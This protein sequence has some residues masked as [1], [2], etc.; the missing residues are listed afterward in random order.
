MQSSAAILYFIFLVSDQVSFVG[1]YTCN[2]ITDSRGGWSVRNVNWVDSIWFILETLLEAKQ[3]I[4]EVNTPFS[5]QRHSLTHDATHITLSWPFSRVPLRKLLLISRTQ[6]CWWQSYFGRY[7]A[8]RA[9]DS[10]YPQANVYKKPG[11]DRVG[12]SP[13]ALNDLKAFS[14]IHRPR[15]VPLSLQHP[16]ISPCK[17]HRSSTWSTLHSSLPPLPALKRK[18]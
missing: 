12:A 18:T 5:I 4:L 10:Q 6:E 1:E 16:L 11:F 14:V 9:C 7:R 3:L 17:L 13:I 8:T 2:W 15:R